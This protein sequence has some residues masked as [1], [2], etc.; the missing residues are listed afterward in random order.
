MPSPSTVG[1]PRARARLQE[2]RL[3]RNID[4]IGD[5]GGG[6]EAPEAHLQWRLAGHAEGRRVDEERRIREG[7]LHL[8]PRQRLRLAAGPAGK[9]LRALRRPVDDADAARSPVEHAVKDG[10]G[11]AAG[12][13]QDDMVEVDIPTGPLLVEIGEKAHDVRV[14][15][16]QPAP[17]QPQGVDGLQRP[18]D[19]ILDA[20]ETERRLLVGNGDVGA[21]KTVCREARDEGVELTGRDLRALIGALDTMLGQ[22]KAMDEGRAGMA[23]GITD[24]AGTCASWVSCQLAITPSAR[25]AARRSRRGSPRIVK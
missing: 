10:A 17:V 4:D 23:Y 1:L 25:S 7:C 20:R 21:G 18:G 2:V 8:R 16:L 12:A 19:G 6:G 13:E 5:E 24:D 11:G 15:A 9:A 14:G 22:P 3:E